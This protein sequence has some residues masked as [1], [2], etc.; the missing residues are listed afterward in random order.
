[1]SPDALMGHTAGGLL[2]PL[3]TKL[4][5]E[6]LNQ[7]KLAPKMTGLGVT[8]GNNYTLKTVGSYYVAPHIFEGRV[9]TGVSLNSGCIIQIA[10]IK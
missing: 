8:D 7:K 3:L 9:Y 6:L 5:V 4:A 1:M 10:P 2:A